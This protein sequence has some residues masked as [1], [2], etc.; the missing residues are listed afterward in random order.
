M[1]DIDELLQRSEMK[2]DILTI[3]NN[4]DS[5]ENYSKKDAVF[6]LLEFLYKH[7]M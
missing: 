7:N 1:K 3:A 5:D 4:L 2:T 6:D